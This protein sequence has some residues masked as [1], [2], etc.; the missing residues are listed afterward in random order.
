LCF[1]VWWLDLYPC[2]WAPQMSGCFSLSLSYIYIY[3][4]IYIYTHTHTYI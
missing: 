2:C 4:Y 3:I 1:C